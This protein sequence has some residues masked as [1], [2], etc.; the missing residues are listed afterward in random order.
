MADGGQLVSTAMSN[1]SMAVTRKGL[2]EK[3]WSEPIVRVATRLGF[4][5]RGLGKLCAR[6]DIPVPPRGW[7]ARKRHGKPVQQTPLGHPETFERIVIEAS[8]QREPVSVYS[9]GHELEREKSLEWR[10][11]VSPDLPI[12]NRLVKMTGAEI[13]RRWSRRPNATVDQL[14]LKR[15]APPQI[16]HTAVS[17]PLLPRALRIWQALL[18]AFDRRG[19]AVSFDAQANTIVS[20]LDECFE[21]T[22]LERRKQVFVQRTW[23]PRMELEP[24]GLLFLRVGGNYSNSGTADKPPR[25]VED[26]LNRFVAGLVRRALEL[27]RDRAVREEREARWRVED[28]QRRRQEQ[29]RLSEI[30]RIRRLRSLALQWARD[31]RLAEFLSDIDQ[32]ARKEPGDESRDRAA[33][34]LAWAQELLRRRDPVAAFINEAWPESALPPPAAMP[35]SWK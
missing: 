29:E 24:S 2:Y 34:R 32:R 21:I 10:I 20:V 18:D 1:Q 25:R 31:R 3:V 11:V 23:G 8:V 5:G 35:W 15:V 19:Y 16:L 6:H 33:K 13:R 30:A 7:W 9:H 22:L 26:R 27:K 14:P 4:S 28:D 12:T 17:A